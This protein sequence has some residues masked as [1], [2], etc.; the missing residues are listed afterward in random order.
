MIPEGIDVFG[1]RAL[2]TAA[3]FMLVRGEE[4]PMNVPGL[5]IGAEV[6]IVGEAP[7]N[8]VGINHLDVIPRDGERRHLYTV[9]RDCLTLVAPNS[10]PAAPIGPEVAAHVLWH[11]R[12]LGY[13]PGSFVSELIRTIAGADP[14]N[15]RLLARGFPAYVR[16]VR[17]AADDLDGID[18]LRAVIQTRVPLA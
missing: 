2:V 1:R 6:A 7:I 5:E 17:I 8:Q 3:P 9:H 18:R 15:R 11:Y 16:A 10:A 13:P 12:Q 14:S 4:H